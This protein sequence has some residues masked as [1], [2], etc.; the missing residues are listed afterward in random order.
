MGT[1]VRNSRGLGHSSV[2]VRSYIFSKFLSSV[3]VLTKG[4]S[5][6]VV[7]PILTGLTGR[8]LSCWQEPPTPE[9]DRKQ[10]RTGT[11]DQEGKGHSRAGMSL[12]KQD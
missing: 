11:G 1:V 12:E 5:I 4:N 7:N 2:F 8:S 9:G 10:M 3:V 6:V